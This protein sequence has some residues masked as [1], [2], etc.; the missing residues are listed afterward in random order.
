MIDKELISIIVPVY[1]VEKYIDRCINSI[2]QQ[3][4]SNLEI[5]LVNDGSLDQ[6][7]HICDNYK[8]KDKRIEVLH[9][10]NGGLSSAR[11]AGIEIATA[12]YIIFID[13]DDY[14]NDTMV[15]NLYKGLKKYDADIA[16]CGKYL[17]DENNNVIEIK[18][19]GK[20]YCINRYEAIERMLLRD[21]IDNSAWDKI[22]RK[23]L[24]KNIR[25]PDGKYYEDIETVYKLFCKCEK[26]V[27]ISTVE[28]HYI[29]REGS[30][31][32]SKFSLKQL[33]SL[34][35]ISNIRQDIIINYPQYKQQ[36]EAM[37][38]LDL[39]TNLQKIYNSKEMH[40]YKEIYS[41]LKKEFKNSIKTILSNKYINTKKKF[42]C[43]L[44]FFN[45]YKIVSLF[46]K[47]IKGRE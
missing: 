36:V 3:T 17:E 22:Y 13:S 39:V 42:M 34:E 9:K 1:N 35:F 5:I 46:K 7:G 23:E 38:Y 19:K 11:N 40:S 21:E 41:K 43:I 12:N 37:Y 28:Y 20:E 14:V 4:Y 6:S 26:I 15:E 47:L 18:N 29:I 27:H 2:L 32:N 8:R 24:F 45:M 31:I 16:C 10:E 30:I 44:I 33:D 25:F